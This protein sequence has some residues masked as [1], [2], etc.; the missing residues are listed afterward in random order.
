MSSGR[1]EEGWKSTRNNKARRGTDLP[2]QVDQGT[3]KFRT[4]FTG[5]EDFDGLPSSPHTAAIQPA[6][7]EAPWPSSQT[8][9]VLDDRAPDRER[10][11]VREVYMDPRPIKQSCGGRNRIGQS[12]DPSWGWLKF[13]GDGAMQKEN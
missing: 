4:P 8:P 2:D 13:P 11:R 1:N 7:T 12:L 6:G 10:R 9:N 5:G 3:L